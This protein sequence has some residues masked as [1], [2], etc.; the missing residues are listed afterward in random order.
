LQIDVNR[1][2]SK[3][4]QIRGNYTFAKNLTTIQL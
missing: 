4:F 2:L 1:R 3:G